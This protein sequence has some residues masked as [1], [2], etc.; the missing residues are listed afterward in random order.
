[1]PERFRQNAGP[2]VAAQVGH[3]KLEFGAPLG[4]RCHPILARTGETVQQHE[5]LTTSDDF[6]VE[7]YAVD[8]FDSPSWLCWRHL[9][10][11]LQFILCPKKKTA[12]AYARAV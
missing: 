7:L 9:H 8:R 5:R 11:L 1:M 10:R 2:A 4:C 3:N 6:K 12:H